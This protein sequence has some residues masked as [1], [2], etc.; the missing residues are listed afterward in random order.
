[1]DDKNYASNYIPLLTHPITS[2]LE[3]L[4]LATNSSSD[5]SS[6]MEACARV[7]AIR[8]RL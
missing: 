4:S 5:G 1:M 6:R 3:R 8:I 7:C 2:L